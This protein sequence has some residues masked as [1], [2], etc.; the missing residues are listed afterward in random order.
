MSHFCTLI[1][2]GSA[3]LIFSILGSVPPVVAQD[4]PFQDKLLSA[5]FD[6]RI[7]KELELSESQVK[8]L[9]TF[10]A[11]IKESQ[12]N[13]GEQ[14]KKMKSQ[15]AENAEIDTK[16]KDFIAKLDEK[17]SEIQKEATDL[18]LPHQIDR[19]KQVTIQV[20]MRETAKNSKKESGLLTPEMMKFLK[21]DSSQE[22]KIRDKTL[23]LQ[24][25]M[26][27]EIKELQEKYRKELMR[28]LTPQQRKKYEEATGDFFV[29]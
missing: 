25:K 2:F 28:E 16:R 24:K 5:L 7:Q 20:M 17:K 27:Q 3:S 13:Y 26:M 29:R 21:I 12:K 23:E 11:S 18:L 8:Q 14:L 22:K 6:P 4:M 15:G 19:L 9:K 1:Y 10:L